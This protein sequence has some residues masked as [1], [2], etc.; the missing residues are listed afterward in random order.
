M[1]NETEMW[2][3]DLLITVYFICLFFLILYWSIVNNVV[4]VSSVQ[5]SDSIAHI[6]VS[7]LFQILFPFRMLH[8]GSIYFKL[9]F[10]FKW[11]VLIL[12]I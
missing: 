6:R 11:F 7:I 5:Q 1:V 2:K 12:K 8:K 10:N 4:L 9:D 3:L